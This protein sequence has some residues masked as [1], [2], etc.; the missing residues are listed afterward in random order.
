MGKGETSLIV[1]T[2]ALL[3]WM[4]ADPRLSSL[5]R[6]A[7]ADRGAPGFVSAVSAFEIANK[8]RLGK[9]E[10]A[11][12]VAARFVEVCRR[13]RLEILPLRADQALLAGRL[14]GAPRDPFDRLIAAQAIIAGLPVLSADSAFRAL[15]AESV[16]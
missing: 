12:P 15:G 1:D 2:H 4:L 6:G 9:L 13:A 8:V 11:R 16:W 5:A 7:M 14:P 10:I 3:W